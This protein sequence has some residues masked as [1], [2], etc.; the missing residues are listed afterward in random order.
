MHR[1]EDKVEGCQGQ[2]AET[3]AAPVLFSDRVA[4]ENFPPFHPWC[5]CAYYIVVPDEQKWIDDYVA[6]RGGDLAVS[7]KDRSHAEE[8]LRRFDDEHKRLELGLRGLSSANIPEHDPPELIG[9]L[10]DLSE[11]VVI[12]TLRKYEKEIVGSETEHAIVVTSSGEIWR[13][14]GNKNSVYPNV[15]L[16]VERLR[17]AWVTHNHPMVS[18]NEY[19]FSQRDINLFMENNLKVLRGVDEFYVYELTRDSQKID[20]YTSVFD[21]DEF[22]ARHERVIIEAKKLGIGYRRYRLRD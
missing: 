9:V 11:D 1:L 3:S 12:S 2:E 21:C 18:D 14:H 8:I 17:G 22:S 5:R 15:D 4:G 6:A 19:S 16:G 7:A 20:E 10:D 13:C